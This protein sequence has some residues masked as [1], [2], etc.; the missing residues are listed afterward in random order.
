MPHAKDV[1]WPAIRTAYEESDHTVEVIAAM[2]GVNRV[3][4]QGRGRREG[5]KP[6][7][8]KARLSRSTDK[9]DPTDIGRLVEALHRTTA[10]LVTGMEA[11]L[12]TA[13]GI[14]EK[15]ARA[16][17]ALAAALGKVIALK[18]EARSGRDERDPDDGAGGAGGFDAD[19]AFE[20]LCQRVERTVAERATGGVERSDDGRTGGGGALLAAL[21]QG[22]P[23]GAGG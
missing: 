20:A 22:G 13:E 9:R 15:D 21:R 4:V 16:L 8:A 18:P 11:R 6:R 12:G 2:H 19:A 7:S 17:G 23:D 5:W 1:D 10:R 14:D 3:T